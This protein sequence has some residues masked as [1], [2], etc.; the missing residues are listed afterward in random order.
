MLRQT[1]QCSFLP[2][3]LHPTRARGWC[4]R[5][6]DGTRGPLLLDGS[7][8]TR[9]QPPRLTDMRAPRWPVLPGTC[10]RR[11]QR[12]RS[13]L[14][15]AQAWAD[16]VVQLLQ[17]LHTLPE[18][19]Q[20]RLVISASMLLLGRCSSAAPAGGHRRRQGHR[21]QPRRLTAAGTGSQL[22]TPLLRCCRAL[23]LPLPLPRRR[24]PPPQVLAA[25]A[26]A[27]TAS[28]REVLRASLNLV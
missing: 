5:A 7:Y 15:R 20:T 18:I 10:C 27:W 1:S 13:S 14:R 6:G 11:L 22:R 4:S 16:A 8:C 17:H 2:P 3:L 9:L 23:C 26:S 25:A 24:C 21:L 12:C 19:T 28:W